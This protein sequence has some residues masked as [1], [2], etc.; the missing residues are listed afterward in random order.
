MGGGAAG[1]GV[2]GVTNEWTGAGVAAGFFS[3]EVNTP[4]GSYHGALRLL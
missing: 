4:N 1:A 3:V 2:A